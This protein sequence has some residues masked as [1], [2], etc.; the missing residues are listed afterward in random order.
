MWCYTILLLF[1]K[2]YDFVLAINEVLDGQKH[3][4]SLALPPYDEKRVVEGREKS[5]S[6][7]RKERMG[8]GVWGGGCSRQHPHYATTFSTR[9]AI[10]FRTTGATFVPSSST[11]FI[12]LSW[13][14]LPTPNC[15]VKR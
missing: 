15:S 10:S 6:V 11:A 7:V 13:G 14:M 9:L 4:P 5:L 2:Q 12:S 8:V 1:Y 3:P